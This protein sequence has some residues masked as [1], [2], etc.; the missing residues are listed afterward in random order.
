MRSIK[1]NRKELIMKILSPR[2]HGYLDYV[3]V[4]LF[5]LAPTLFGFAGTA[6][7]LCYVLAAVHAGLTLLTAVPLG[8]AKIIPFPVHG[9]LEAAVAVFLL[10][11][12]WV[13]N[14]S[15]VDAARNFF[16]ASGVLIALVWVV[17]D[18]RAASV[19]TRTVGIGYAERR[20]YS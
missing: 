14:F 15:Y 9:A 3:V 13:F 19:S 6:A 2:V 4:A 12:P 10:A 8:I 16:I 18:Y 11:S 1:H 17:T 7:T 5:L 20:S